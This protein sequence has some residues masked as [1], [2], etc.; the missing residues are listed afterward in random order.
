MRNPSRIRRGEVERAAHL[1][2]H[3]FRTLAFGPIALE[4]PPR[5]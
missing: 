4:L 5:F 1:L 2:L 3:D